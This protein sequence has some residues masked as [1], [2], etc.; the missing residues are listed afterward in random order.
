MRASRRFTLPAVAAATAMFLMLPSAVAAAG[1]PTTPPV[2]S[3][4]LYR[5]A[6]Y[7]RQPTSTTCVPTSTKVMLSMA[8]DGVAGERIYAT[9]AGIGSISSYA[10]AHDFLPDG[11]PGSDPAGWAASLNHFG[12]A[13]ARVYVVKMYDSVDA[14]MRAA[15]R[16]IRATGK[17]VGI[18]GLNGQHA[19]IMTGFRAT[20]DPAQKPSFRITSVTV[21]DVY[22][23]SHASF[24]RR[25]SFG[26]YA[27]IDSTVVNPAT[28]AGGWRT[29]YAHYVLVVP[30]H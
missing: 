24:A 18:V 15:V 20:A 13:G 8:R 3:V 4:E 5:A 16:A 30:T 1:P 21:S 19:Q 11:I 29:W 2:T 7:M 28:G 26:L 27:E 14:A 17:P 25:F 10:R 9:A 6:D 22:S 23:F 12:F